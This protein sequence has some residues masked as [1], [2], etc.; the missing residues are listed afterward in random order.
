MC[1]SN[2][3]TGNDFLYHSYHS[4]AGCDTGFFEG[5]LGV[6]RFTAEIHRSRI[7]FDRYKFRSLSDIHEREDKI[8]FRK[9]QPEVE[10]A[11][12]GP[13]W[14]FRGRRLPD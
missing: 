12:T 13:P 4:T 5:L 14:G 7:F 2:F 8:K 11:R 6:G 9:P 1:G 3:R 10:E